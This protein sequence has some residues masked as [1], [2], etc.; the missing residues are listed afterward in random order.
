MQLVFTTEGDSEKQLKLSTG[1]DPLRKTG[2]SW[3]LAMQ[4]AL[5]F[6]YNMENSWKWERGRWPSHH[7]PDYCAVSSVPFEGN[8]YKLFLLLSMY[9]IFIFSCYFIQEFF[10]C[11]DFLK[12]SFPLFISNIGVCIIFLFW[13]QLK[14]YLQKRLQFAYYIYSS[15]LCGPI[16]AG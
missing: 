5:K 12:K 2:S 15:Y 1:P 3:I 11:K 16:Y 10:E 9:L 14:D 13:C 8:I 6:M 7:Y 4:Q